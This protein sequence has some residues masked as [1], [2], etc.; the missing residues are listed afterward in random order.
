MPQTVQTVYRI[1]RR[2]QTVDRVDH[3]MQ[4]G[5]FRLSRSRLQTETVAR[6]LHIKQTVECRLYK[7][8]VMSRQMSDECWMLGGWYDD[9]NI[10]WLTVTLIQLR[11]ISL[12]IHHGS[13][14]SGLKQRTKDVIG[15][16]INRFFEK[17]WRK[18]ISK[19]KT[20]NKLNDKKSSLLVSQSF[21]NTLCISKFFL[22][23]P[24]ESRYI[25]ASYKMH[26]V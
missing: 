1:G 5:D 20:M 2:P 15:D 14:K 23:M 3:R 26:V 13:A 22:Q 4:T 8:I 6:R 24:F 12:S 18:T 7:Q 19:I 21:S 16:S 17:A 10:N 25:S 9:G 11:N